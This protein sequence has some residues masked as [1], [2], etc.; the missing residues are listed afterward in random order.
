MSLG[1]VANVVNTLESKAYLN[2]E[3]LTDIFSLV[4]A[5]FNFFIDQI[6]LL[7]AGIQQRGLDM[8]VLS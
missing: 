5:A 2:F 7:H 8:H 3:L 6:A 1:D 4:A